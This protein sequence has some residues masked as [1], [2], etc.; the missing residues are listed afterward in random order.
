[1]VRTEEKRVEVLQ[2][3]VATTRILVFKLAQCIPILSCTSVYH[4]LKDLHRRLYS[5][6]MRHELKQMDLAK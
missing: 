3:I 6:Q 1:M 2:Q 4:T 5:V